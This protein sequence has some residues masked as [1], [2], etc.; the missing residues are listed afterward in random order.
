MIEFLDLALAKSK[1][2]G[3]FAAERLNLQPNF[4]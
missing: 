3:T 4:I 1:N 2:Y